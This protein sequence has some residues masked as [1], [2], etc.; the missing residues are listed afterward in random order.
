MQL[1]KPP[2]F[3]QNAYVMLKCHKRSESSGKEEVT[4][5]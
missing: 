4:E 5:I 2:P 3:P 1:S